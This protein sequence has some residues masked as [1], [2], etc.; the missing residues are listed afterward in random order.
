MCW[1]TGNHS[2]VKLARDAIVDT[3]ADAPNVTEQHTSGEQLGG[4][5]P[6]LHQQKQG[7]EALACSSVGLL[8]GLAHRSRPHYG[9]QFHPESVATQYGIALLRNFRDLAAEH[10]RRRGGPAAEQ[11]PP[12]M[13]VKVP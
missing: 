10:I 6:R 3:S 12:A 13:C 11:L 5:A 7:D 9:V 2:A 1:T 4:Q 8:M